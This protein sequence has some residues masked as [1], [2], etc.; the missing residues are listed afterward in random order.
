MRRLA[1]AAVLGVSL[2]AALGGC[3]TP[4]PDPSDPSEARVSSTPGAPTGAALHRAVADDDAAAV[5]T[6]LHEG[7][8]VDARDADGRTPLLA[9]TRQ[10]SAGLARL[11]LEAGADPD[12]QD[13]LQDSAF[14]YAGAEGLDDILRLTLEHG[15][16]VT[17]TNRFG[18]TAL[19]P[20]SEHG[21]VSTV[22]ILLDAGVPVDHVND[23]SWT[24]LHEAI[25]L[26]DGSADQVEVVR[27]LLDAGA[28]PTVRDGQGVLPRDLAASRGYDAIVAELDRGR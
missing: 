9:A 11:L 18:G 13:R 7:A 25:V 5:A 8:A 15:A 2:A 28:D 26:G 6:A 21:H 20:A 3:T 27:L 12:A 1:A 22:R 19:I 14:L 23:L 10:G 24:A 16:D 4:E 17:S